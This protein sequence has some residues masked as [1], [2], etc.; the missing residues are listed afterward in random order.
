MPAATTARACCTSRCDPVGRDCVGGNA[1]AATEDTGNAPMG[2][3]ASV[4]STGMAIDYRGTACHKRVLSK[5]RRLHRTQLTVGS[6]SVQTPEVPRQSNDILG[7]TPSTQSWPQTSSRATGRWQG[8]DDRRALGE[9]WHNGEL[10]GN[11]LVF[12]IQRLM[13]PSRNRVFESGKRLFERYLHPSQ[14][15]RLPAQVRSPV[16][17]LPSCFFLL[18][19]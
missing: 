11:R 5:I 8:K 9:Q 2:N 13:R 7:H 17:P 4:P 1:M 15:S 10:T 12:H 16:T 6:V 3:A 19:P 14:A 18:F